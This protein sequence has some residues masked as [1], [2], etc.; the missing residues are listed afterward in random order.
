LAKKDKAML[1]MA[2]IFLNRLTIN[3]LRKPLIKEIP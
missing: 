2:L 1:V 3:G